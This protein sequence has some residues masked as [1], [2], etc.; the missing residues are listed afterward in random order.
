M[1]SFDECNHL[2]AGAY[3]DTALTNTDMHHATEALETI[4]TALVNEPNYFKVWET[5][6]H[7]IGQAEHVPFQKVLAT[8]RTHFEQQIRDAEIARISKVFSKDPEAGWLEWLMAYAMALS[9]WR[10][11]IC[12]AFCEATLSF[13][14]G[15]KQHV[16]RLRQLAKQTLYGRS[17]D[18]Y[19]TLIY[20]AEQEAFPKS[21]RAKI[22]VQAA[23]IQL[24]D[25]MTPD[26]ARRLLQCAEELAPEERLVQRGWGAYWIQQKDFDR[27]RTCLQ[28]A[29]KRDPLLVEGY[30]FMGDCYDRLNDLDA[31]EEWYREA[32]SVNSGYSS[33]Y[34]RLMQLYGRA[35]L[36]ATH[37]AQLQPLLE[38]AISIDP[39][40]TYLCYLDMGYVYE[41]NQNYQR[42]YE[43]YIKAIE[44]DET[45]LSGYI[46]LGNAALAEKD[47]M[48]AEEAFQKAMKVAPEAFDG[49]WWMALLAEEREHW[50]EALDWYRQSLPRRPQWE[51]TIRGKIGSMELALERYE[52]AQTELIE[53]LRVEP[54]NG[55]VLSS[56]L[57]LADDYAQAKKPTTAQ[58]IYEAI[59]QIKG[60]SYEADY[61][62]RLGNM[63]YYLGEYL[64]AVEFYQKAIALNSNEVDYFSNMAFAWEMVRIPGQRLIELDNALSALQ[65]G[66]ELI[67]EK[68]KLNPLLEQNTEFSPDSYAKRIE[69]LE[70]EHR[71]VMNCGE[72]ALAFL[73]EVPLLSIDISSDLIPYV[74]PD[75]R[76]SSIDATLNDLIGAVQDRF[77]Q[78]FG[79]DL[80][81][82]TFREITYAARGT[83][84]IKLSG[85]SLISG[86]MPPNTRFFP[87]HRE[88]LP[89]LQGE[90]EE[91]IDPQTGATGYWIGEADWPAVEQQGLPLWQVM[92]Y[93]LRYMEESLRYYIGSF[94][95]HQWVAD[96]VESRIASHKPEV[97]EQI[98]RTPEK[99]TALTQVLKGL[100]SEQVS[101][102]AFEQIC[103]KFVE[104]LAAGT[105]LLSV[106]EH[107][108]SLPDILP[109]LPGNDS[110]YSFYRIGKSFERELDRSIIRDHREPFLAMESERWQKMLEIIASAVSEQKYV[111]LLLEKAELRPFVRKLV[112]MAFSEIPVLSRQELLPGLEDRIAGEI[113]LVEA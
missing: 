3:Y 47:Y 46:F 45:Q 90:I 30:L 59:R 79:V 18:S 24:Y 108:R 74:G 94:I 77:R 64:K 26:D 54:E 4:R 66:L 27:A 111:V 52:E 33:E 69:N 91:G 32:I 58:D 73:P 68:I 22:Y 76:Q 34:I 37:E 89:P 95:D 88:D 41:Q 43:W 23:E 50:Q 107:L 17:V 103:E 16:L 14:E 25:F 9:E 65:K 44:L 21:L 29:I 40:Y 7:Y 97:Y 15:F 112:E 49:Y 61:L 86:R 28:E 62:N 5:I 109:A 98:M 102:A 70:L 87:G 92:E 100:V 75:R 56:L 105:N 80:T 1:L 101:I 12:L 85:L 55:E 104:L 53:A 67:V 36:F 20:L 83:C 57:N 72:Q 81:P 51:G 63:N 84:I 38:R 78:K 96:R 106:I 71:L 19:D 11:T 8:L 110:R 93:P 6:D 10:L 31:A 99:I 2:I 82:I 13:P 35:E 39:E 60:Q 42:A 113:E 48:R